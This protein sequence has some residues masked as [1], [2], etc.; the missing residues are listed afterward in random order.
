M[1]R[2][3][4]IAWLAAAALAAWTALPAGAAPLAAQGTEAQMVTVTVTPQDLPAT[5]EW[6]FAVVMNTHVR[7]LDDDLVA[8]AALVD[9]Q[10]GTHAPL[11]WRGDPPGS[12]HRRG[13]LVF[14]PLVPRPAVIELKLQRP[15][16]AAPRLFR[17]TA[18]AQ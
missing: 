14:A 18:P 10:G 1:R 8:G 11:A 6:Q 12:H 3:R 13:V 5:G 16:E 17:W 2:P 7:P 9:A 4:L 15:G